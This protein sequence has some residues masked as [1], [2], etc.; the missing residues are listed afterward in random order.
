MPATPR[1]RRRSPATPGAR[2]LADVLADNVRDLRVLRRQ[3]QEQ[4]ATN[5]RRLTQ[6]TWSAVTVSDVEH[7]KRTVSVD[8]LVAL[9]LILD[10]SVVDLLDPTGVEG[11][12]TAPVDIGTNGHVGAAGLRAWLR[13][14][15]RVHAAGPASYTVTPVP[16]RDD[17]YDAVMTDD[18]MTAVR[19]EPLVLPDE[20]TKPRPRTSSASEKKANTTKRRT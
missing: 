16:G 3:T 8:E 14:V 5:M 13:G 9:A 17:E 1:R 11:R 20:K 6:D 18:W 19:P 7:A 2:F 15:I 12:H 10:T 4:L